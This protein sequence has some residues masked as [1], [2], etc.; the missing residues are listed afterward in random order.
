MNTIVCIKLVIALIQYFY[1]NIW[2][3]LLVTSCEICKSHKMLILCI[4]LDK[5]PYEIKA[6]GQFTQC[7][8]T[9]PA[10]FP[11]SFHPMP[12]YPIYPIAK[13]TRMA[14]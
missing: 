8:L 1:F 5:Y 2:T 11:M 3:D 10:F 7:H 13:F 14:I 12:T 6:L 4:V 9:Q